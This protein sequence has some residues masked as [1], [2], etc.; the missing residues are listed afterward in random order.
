MKQKD[1]NK[2]MKEVQRQQIKKM[3]KSQIGLGHCD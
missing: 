1:R 2:L 3:A